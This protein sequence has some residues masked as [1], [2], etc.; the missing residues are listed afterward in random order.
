MF[1]LNPASLDSDN[2]SES[3]KLY[4]KNNN[5][6][7]K[8][9]ANKVTF[10]DN[11]VDIANS[12]SNSNPNPN[13]NSNSNQNPN[14]NP[15]S[16]NHQQGNQEKIQ[17]ISNLISKLHTSSDDDNEDNNFRELLNEHENANGTGTGSKKISQTYGTV[18]LGSVIDD[19][20]NKMQSVSDNN[21]T[22]A[23]YLNSH[24]NNSFSN[25]DESYSKTF[26]N[27]DFNSLN[28]GTGT[29]LNLDNN[30]LLTKLDYIVHLL[31]EQ[32]GEKTNHITEELVLYLFLGIFI[33]FV[34]DSFARASKYV[35]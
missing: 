24:Q 11:V 25:L 2:N 21:I 31:E 32:R 12:N 30:K 5:K 1:Q 27:Y 22:N 4:K 7:F 9:R 33:I 34:L 23:T 6:T 8:N 13:P 16:N 28:N 35:R 19:E 10:S 3:V 18:K 26:G 17:N 15:N 20:L 29:G 14:S